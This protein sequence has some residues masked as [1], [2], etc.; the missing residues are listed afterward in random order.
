MKHK[1]CVIRVEVNKPI[2]NKGKARKFLRSLI[3]K[4][5]MKE[6]YGPV[7]SY[8]KMEGNRGITAFAVIETSHIAL[9]IWDEKSPSLV[10][11]DVYSCKDFEPQRVFD[12]LD[13]MEPTKIDYKF[14]DR[15]QEFIKIL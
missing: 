4:I 8:C 7:A 11:F 9:H 15:E 1:H 2:I 10:Q 5:E 14:F 6:M 13:V 3:K 12:H